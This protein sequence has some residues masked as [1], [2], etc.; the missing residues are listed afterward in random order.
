MLLRMPIGF[1]WRFRN[2]FK[3]N[4]YKNGMRPFKTLRNAFYIPIARYRTANNRLPIEKGSW[5]DTERSQRVC[6]LCNRN[7]LGDEFHYLFECEFFKETRRL[8]LPSFYRKHV[9]TLKFQTLM[10]STKIKLLQ[11]LSWFIYIILSK[12]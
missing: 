7:E 4:I 5:N 12:F 8:Y 3:C 10:T 1:V 2:V 6:T 9:N 11:Q